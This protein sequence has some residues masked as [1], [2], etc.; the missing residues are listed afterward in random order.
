ML[1]TGFFVKTEE[2]LEGF[3]TY[4]SMNEYYTYDENTLTA[5]GDLGTKYKIG[6]YVKVYYKDSN[7]E[8]LLIDFKL[9]ERRKKNYYQK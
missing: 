3:V 6:D 4:Q 9:Y 2:G 5:Y 7:K 1:E 8:K